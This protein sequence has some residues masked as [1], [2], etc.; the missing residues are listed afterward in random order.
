MITF[1]WVT[2]PIAEC[3]CF[4]EYNT[5]LTSFCD[6][7]NPPEIYLQE[8]MY[9]FVYFCL[10]G[11]A[12]TVYES[13]HARGGIVAAAASIH[14][15]I[16]MHDPRHVCDLHHSSRQCWIP[17]IEARDRTHVLMNT[18]WVHYY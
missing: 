13:S 12:T 15:A 9:L 1:D 10:S 2:L 8:F 11:T 5:S 14:Q 4:V 6:K 17:Q 16:A 18:S 3:L 7:C